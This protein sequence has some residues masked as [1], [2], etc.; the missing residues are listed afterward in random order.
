M[1][2]ADRGERRATRRIKAAKLLQYTHFDAEHAEQRLV[3]ELGMTRTLDLSE[4]GLAFLSSEPLP[5]A[6]GIA[7]DLASGDELLSLQARIVAVQEVEE[8]SYRIGTRFTGLSE[9]DRETL[10]R[11]VSAG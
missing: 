2:E 5:V 8:G 7:I 9:E 10:R 6:W 4:G 1:T 11:I 3:D